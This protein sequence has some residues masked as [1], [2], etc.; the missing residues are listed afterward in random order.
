MK[1]HV[2]NEPFPRIKTKLYIKR[3]ENNVESR[4]QTVSERQAHNESSTII[5]SLGLFETLWP[6][7]GKVQETNAKVEKEA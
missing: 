1:K 2:T 4:E 6:S 5:P 7:R 3:T